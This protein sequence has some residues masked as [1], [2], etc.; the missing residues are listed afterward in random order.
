MPA[1]SRSPKKS[2]R[3]SKSRT[4]NRNR[5]R[6]PER[7]ERD[8]RP[9]SGARAR[10]FERSESP[11]RSERGS[12]S[13][14]PA[15]RRPAIRTRSEGTQD[16]RRG[17]GERSRPRGSERTERGE[18]D[19]RRTPAR[20]NER[21]E[22]ERRFS[23]EDSGRFDRGERSRRVGRDDAPSRSPHRARLE[24]SSR[25]RGTDVKPK[26]HPF[27]EEL[28]SAQRAKLK[29]AAHALK[30]VVLVGAAGFSRNVLAE[31]ESALA[32]HELIKIQLPA[33]TEASDKKDAIA[34]FV[35]LLPEHAHVVGRLGRTVIL[36]LEK[37][38]SEAKIKLKDL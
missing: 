22:G 17:D 33:Q 28:T 3:P 18:R 6:R 20:R 27:R 25:A 8:E 9:S 19:Y 29:G 10:G 16:N 13:G 34:S 1:Q 38:P 31:I 4:P 5:G 30:P 26:L 23:R 24:R 32:T 11:K 15:P 12:T 37:K 2:S 14:R 21:G 7:E 36:Y 35:P